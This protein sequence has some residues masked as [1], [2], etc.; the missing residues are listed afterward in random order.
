M[1]VS[2]QHASD[3][4][5]RYIAGKSSVPMFVEG[6]SLDVLRDLP[7]DVFDCCMT[8]P[9]YWGQRQYEA[10]GIGLERDFRDYIRNLAANCQEVHRVLQ[11][12]GS[13][14]L[15][16][17]DAYTNKRLAGLPWRVALTLTDEQGWLLRN[18]VIWHKVKGSPDNAKDKLRNVHEHV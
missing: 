18:D 5:R 8:S 7:D 13:F 17:G 12:S 14:W 2:Q 15:N 6:D 11:P 16:I 9:P 4:L 3:S 1:A 10:L